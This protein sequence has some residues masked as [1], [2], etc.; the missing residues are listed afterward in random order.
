M[1]RLKN[2]IVN[3]VILYC[4]LACW[5]VALESDLPPEFIVSK[6]AVLRLGERDFFSGAYEP[7]DLTIRAWY[8]GER[9]KQSDPNASGQKR[10]NG[11]NYFE[12]RKY[13]GYVYCYGI[14]IKRDFNQK[15]LL[16]VYPYHKEWLNE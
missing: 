7:Q 2:R 12:Y 6:H 13:T 16:T 5:G 4:K 14:K 1:Q 10:P 11:F 3:W 8:E 9:L 15:T